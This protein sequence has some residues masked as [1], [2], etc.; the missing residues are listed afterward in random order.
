MDN[1]TEEQFLD[2]TRIQKS[3]DTNMYDLN[4]VIELSEE[5]L[6]KEEIKI[7]MEHYEELAEKFLLDDYE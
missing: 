7:I 3:G 1:I 2:Y 5:G 4:A 6:T